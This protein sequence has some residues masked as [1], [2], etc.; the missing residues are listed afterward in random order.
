MIA[1]AHLVA[2]SCYVG[3]A[4]LAAAPFVRPVSAPVRTVCGLLAA[5]VTAH[6]LA[7]A[8]ITLVA[9]RAPLTGMGPALSFGA[10]VLAAT[11]LLVEL[12]AR[13]ASLSLIAAP[14][15]AIATTSAM[16]VGLDP[17]PG[18]GGGLRSTWLFA[19]IALSFLGLAAFATSAAAGTIYLLERREL[20]RRRFGSL[21]R[22][23]PPLETLD[24]V[25]H[26]AAVGGWLAL[27]L[28]TALAFSYSAT[29]NAV[30][31]A[32]VVW[33]MA[34]WVSVTALVAGRL[35]GGWRAH[36]AALASSVAFSVVALLY[37]A[38]R[39]LVGTGRTFL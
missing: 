31:L 20:R 36:R 37:V 19:H 38:V 11:L 5:G 9:G 3:A 10:F 35:L 26:V 1:I 8:Q 32:Q 29:Y 14:L 39:T 27:T 2:T 15:A 4:A 25:N 33:G 6:A 34:A 7:L 16:L 12:L 17:L 18:P 23:F 22:L 30:D 24:R 28:G 13:D 21:F